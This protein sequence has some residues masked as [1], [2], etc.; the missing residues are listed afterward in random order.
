MSNVSYRQAIEAIKSGMIS[1]KNLSEADK[2]SIAESLLNIE[3]PTSSR[4]L[5]EEISLSF[6]PEQKESLESYLSQ[7]ENIRQS[8]IDQ[9]IEESI[10]SAR[11]LTDLRD[12]LKSKLHTATDEV[13]ELE[14]IANELQ[15]R[16]LNDI[17][18]KEE[19]QIK[20]L[21]RN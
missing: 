15:E 20:D 13:Q 7:L 17:A 1:S 12:E 11:R 16:K 4:Q 10:T 19:Q 8:N 14:K 2:T 9:R 3:T 5:E 18:G 6:S 21:G